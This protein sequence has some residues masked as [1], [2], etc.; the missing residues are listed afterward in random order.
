MLTPLG[1]TGSVRCVSREGLGNPRIP[2]RPGAAVC[3]ALLVL[4]SAFRFARSNR[5]VFA[6]RAEQRGYREIHSRRHVWMAIV[7]APS[8]LMAQNTAQHFLSWLQWMS[9][10][11]RRHVVFYRSAAMLNASTQAGLM[12]QAPL[13]RVLKRRFPGAIR[14]NFGAKFLVNRKGMR[15]QTR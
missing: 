9:T 1:A 3:L 6:R 5:S 2:H 8:I 10:A 4:A 11:I 13:Y 12:R 15:A 7:L 14:T